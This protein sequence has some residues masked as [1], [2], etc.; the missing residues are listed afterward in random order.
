MQ[1]LTEI[2]VGQDGGRCCAVP[3]LLFKSTNLIP[4]LQQMLAI[5]QI[6]KITLGY[7][8]VITK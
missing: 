5:V 8:N 1:G 3:E 7:Y 6:D 2:I 4:A